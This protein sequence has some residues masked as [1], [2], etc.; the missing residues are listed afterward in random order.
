MQAYH[1][2]SSSVAA[3]QLAGE[4][5]I[6]CWEMKKEYMYALILTHVFFADFMMKILFME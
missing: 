1:W 4:A 5:V 2:C 3:V 6:P